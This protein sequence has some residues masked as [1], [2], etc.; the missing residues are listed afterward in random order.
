[1]KKLTVI[2]LSFLAL[3]I[4]FLPVANGTEAI[5]KGETLFNEYGCNKCHANGEKL[6]GILHS[7]KYKEEG[8]LEAAINKCIQTAAKRDALDPK[9]EDMKNLIQ[10]IRSFDEYHQDD[11]K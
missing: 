10:Y 5:K 4:V 2:G 6:K 1:M 11:T 3:L 9:S 8:K 7:D